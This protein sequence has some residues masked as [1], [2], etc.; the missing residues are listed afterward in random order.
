MVKINKIIIAAIFS[1][2]MVLPMGA[3]NLLM[4][5]RGEPTPVT[6]DPETFGDADITYVCE[7]L[8][9]LSTY[10]DKTKTDFDGV[11]AY[12]DEV[13]GYEV[14][15]STAMGNN[16]AATLV[17]DSAMA[18]VYWH[19]YNQELNIVLSDTAGGT[20]PVAKPAVTS[21]SY[22]C[23]VAQMEDSKHV[24]GMGY[25][26]QLEDGSYIVYDG[27]YAT[28]ADKIENYLL[29]NYEGVG[30]PIIR[31]WVLTHSHNDHFPVFQ[32]F[33][34]RAKTN[35]K[36]IVEN[37]IVSPLNEESYDF[38]DK[39]ETLYLNTDF[40]EDVACFTGAKVVFAHT[41][42]KFTFCNLNME[43]LYTAESFYKTTDTIDNFNT[44]SLVTRLYDSVYSA[45]FLGDVGI[46]GAILMENL[47]GAY[48]KSDMCQISHHGVEDVHLSF[49]A[50]V[51]AQILFYP[52][53]RSLY[54]Q[55]ERHYEERKEM[56][57]WDCT[58][59]ILIAG[60][61]QYV[62][63]WWTSYPSDDPLYIP[64]YY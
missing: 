44:T 49:Y 5:D 1:V 21:G 14:Y 2:A 53:N 20:L 52:C 7:D 8:S 9:V 22:A 37:V 29:E 43:I 27:A 46:Q 10:N 58:K 13:L 30:K 34:K 64:D 3:C 41:G 55:K 61:G 19:S 6:I 31:A 26:I 54:D 33:S 42:M 15:S 48:L 11:C 32:E 47:Y 40:Y 38:P 12:Y 62:R 57:S 60:L 25:V 4:P 23:T 17:K 36:F 45:L 59:E 16:F 18:H 24:N 39:E 51:E 50:Y 28:Q 35:E 63:E 56:E